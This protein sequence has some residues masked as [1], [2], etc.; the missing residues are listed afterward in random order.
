MEKKGNLSDFEHSCWYQMSW[1]EH[2]KTAVLLGLS[3]NRLWGLQGMAP[4]KKKES[5]VGGSCLG[6]NVLLLPEVRGEWPH[7]KLIGREQ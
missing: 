2:F 3:H 4:K 6:G 5:P 7:F 1:S